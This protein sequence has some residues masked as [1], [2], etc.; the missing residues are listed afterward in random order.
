[1]AGEGQDE[2]D[3]GRRIRMFDTDG[4][5][6]ESCRDIWTLIEPAKREIARAYWERYAQSDE[7]TRPIPPEKIEE[8]TD[9]IVP[10]IEAKHAAL[11]DPQWVEMTR[12][13]VESGPKP[14]F[15]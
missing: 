1:M 14:T 6:E 3:L 5:L 2:I 12:G 10:H 4:R 13:Y 11:T 15:R 7:I 8:L 9:R